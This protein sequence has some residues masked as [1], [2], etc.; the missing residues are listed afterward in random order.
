MIRVTL[1]QFRVEAVFG[2]G[3]LA[4]LGIALA[5]TGAHLDLVNGAFQAGCRAARD[6]ASTPNPVVGADQGL[7]TLVGLAAIAAPLAIGLFY[8]APL[9]ARELETG[10]FRLAW[11]QSVT[12]GRW[13]LVKVG[14]IGLASVAISALLTWAVD[15]WQG[16]LDAATKNRFDPYLFSVH[17]VVPI[18]YAAFAFALGVAA[19]VVLRRTVAAMAVTLVAFILARVAVT[20]WIRPGLA[21]PLHR[22][23]SFWAA[24]PTVSLQAPA[25]TLSLVSSPVMIPNAWVYSTALVDKSGAGPTSEA[26][27]HA[28]PA[29]ASV[30]PAA[31]AVHSC[32]A[33]LASSF[34]TAVTY[35]PASRFWPFQWGELGIF[36][37]AG[38]LL[39]FLSYWWLRRR[40]A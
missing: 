23:L 8:G 27:L 26:M 20:D 30:P 39:G 16:P 35:Q 5:I 18:G 7:Q 10:T 3:L 12:R 36:L 33:K 11:S 28:C 4:I 17:G 15:W 29:L 38:L 9:I 21:A 2:F 40:Y 32:L 25:G 24:H 31:T 1:R 19:G 14:L 13:L 6:C 34:H 22:A 37:A